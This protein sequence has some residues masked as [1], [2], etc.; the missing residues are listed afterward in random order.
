MHNMAKLAVGI[1]LVGLMTS[2]ALF[3][4]TAFSKDGLDGGD[5][6]SPSRH[7]QD[8]DDRQVRSG[9]GGDGGSSGG[10]T[11]RSGNGSGSTA[12]SSNLDGSF[13][14][15]AHPQGASLIGRIPSGLFINFN[16]R[17]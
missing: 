6:G 5:H 9:T 13:R 16:D 15:I 10:A 2:A 3:G 17:F 4:G 8:V 1:S 7:G 11:D 12:I 14:S